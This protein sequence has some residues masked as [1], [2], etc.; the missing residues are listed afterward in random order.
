MI[1]EYLRPALG[2]AFVIALPMLPADAWWTG[3]VFAVALLSYIVARVLVLVEP[4]ARRFIVE[5]PLPL[6]M[7]LGEAVF[8]TL[9]LVLAMV[10]VHERGLLA[11]G[12]A[13]G[14]IVAIGYL[15]AHGAGLVTAEALIGPSEAPARP[16]MRRFIVIA[17]FF[18]E[19]AVLL[20]T[21]MATEGA[22]VSMM[23]SPWSPW[24]SLTLPIVGI[25][26]LFAC[27]VPITRISRA[28]D[29]PERLPIDALLIQI[30]ALFVYALTGTLPL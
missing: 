8:V 29:D 7:H 9:A 21:L 11:I 15:L 23:Q 16:G 1:R 5:H 14:T 13:T 26:V 28:A 6:W 12:A 3:V 20:S 24:Q 30:A 17:T 25:V 10:V 18:A 27:Y 22:R 19:E 4:E 2:L